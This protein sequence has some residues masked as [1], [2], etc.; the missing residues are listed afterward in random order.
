MTAGKRIERE[1]CHNSWKINWPA[2]FLCQIHTQAVRC[3]KQKQ[4]AASERPKR[5]LRH[6]TKSRWVLGTKPRIHG[7]A[8]PPMRRHEG[9]APLGSV[10]CRSPPP[11]GP[12][13]RAPLP[14]CSPAPPRRRARPAGSWAGPRG[15][16]VPPTPADGH[17]GGRGRRG[18]LGWGPAEA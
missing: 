5:T 2:F 7:C 1:E 11:R 8:L 9:T 4:V 13:R 16:P 6:Q 15:A 14:R 18:K 17:G 12:A 10:L 3:E